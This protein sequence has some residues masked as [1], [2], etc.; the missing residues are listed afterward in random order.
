MKFKAVD[1]LPFDILLSVGR[2]MTPA[3]SINP[4]LSCNIKRSTTISPL[5]PELVHQVFHLAAAS[6]RHSALDICL[7]ASWA[8]R[9]AL[10]HLFRAVVIR[11]IVAFSK[12]KKYIANPPYIP[13]NSDFLP[14][15]AV[16][17][18]WISGIG[19]YPILPVFESCDNVTHWAMGIDLFSQLV[20]SVLNSPW[21]FNTCSLARKQDIR[22]TVT[23]YQ[24]LNRVS[25]LTPLTSGIFDKVTYIR[26]TNTDAYETH[27]LSDFSRLSHVSL[28]YYGYHKATQL[29]SFLDLKPLNMLVVSFDKAVVQVAD[30][31]RLEKWVRNKRKTDDRVYLVECHRVYSSDDWNKEVGGGDNIWDRAVRYTHKWDRYHSD[32]TAVK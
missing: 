3:S 11:D 9:I 12:F 15:S 23:D 10:P 21:Q 20:R 24:T 7:V 18:V 31:K 29:Q 32:A 27:N 4:T 17:G 30:L 8:R 25:G 1:L 13:A 19:G 26:F 6:S 16:N 28:P 22:L 2:S 14:A 5:P